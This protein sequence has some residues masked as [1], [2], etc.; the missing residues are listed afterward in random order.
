MNL[1]TTDL[2]PDHFAQPERFDSGLLQIYHPR[3]MGQ[4]LQVFQAVGLNPGFSH[5]SL[6]RSIFFFRLRFRESNRSIREAASGKYKH[7]S[8][9][10]SA[11]IQLILILLSLIVGCNKQPDKVPTTTATPTIASLVP[12]ATDLVIGMGA[13]DRLVAVCTFDSARSD[14]GSLPKAGDYKTIDWELLASLKPTVMCTA[15]SADRQPQGF[16]DRAAAL[17]IQVIDEKVDRLADVDTAIDRLGS[18]LKIPDL[19]ETAKAKMHARLD[20]VR[21]RAAG[22]PPVEVL[23]FVDP[24][25]NMLAGPNTY[26]DDILTLAGGTNAAAGLAPYPQIDRETLLRLNPQVIIQLITSSAPQDRAKAAEVWKQYPQLRAVAAGR[27]YPIYDQYALL[28][29]WHVTNLAEEIAE[30]LH[31]RNPSPPSPTTAPAR[32]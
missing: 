10:E 32:P 1:R 12:S 31:P 27:V 15:I 29:G 6:A 8:A 14:V 2:F 21:A 3:A 20:A 28:P 4:R 7:H 22:Q 24:A 25:G 30:C 5:P 18:A 19:A 16:K 9:S 17:N 26:L 11:V 13:K 23:V